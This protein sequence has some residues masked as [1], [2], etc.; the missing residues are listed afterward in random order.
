[1][2]R[3]SN[4]GRESGPATGPAAVVDE[5]AE[6]TP[7]DLRG[8]LLRTPLGI[9][10]RRPRLS[11]RLACG[12]RGA[13]Q[14]SYRV[15][16]AASPADLADPHRVLWDSGQVGSPDEVLVTYDGP[17]LQSA[18]RYHWQVDV[19][20]EGDRPGGSARSWFETGLLH[21]DDWVAAW[22]GRDQNGRP[23]MDPPTDDDLPDELRSLSA[24]M[25]L[26]RPFDLP[27]RP[28]RARVYVTAR[29]L[30]E[31][32]VNG[33]RVGDAELAP[34][35]TEYHHRIPYQ[36]YD[37][38]D[39]LVEGANVLAGVV[40][41]G[42][43]SGYVG[44]DGRRAGRHY[45]DNP[46][47]LAQLVLQFP[48]GSERVVGT[49]SD[50]LERPGPLRHAD[51][52][53]GEYYD[54]REELS[55]WDQ[56]GYD[57]SGWAPAAV[58][59]TVTGPL[60][61]AADEPVR[62]VAELPAVDVFRRPDG[63]YIV[64]LGQNMA[65]RVRLTVR[66]APAGA[67]IQL[68]H[69]EMLTGD[70]EPYTANLRSADA[71]DVYVAAGRPVEVFEPR[72]TYHGFRYV[73]VT[74]YPG[75]LAADDIRGRV[76]SSDTPEA[77]EFACSDAT[78]NQLQSNIRWSQRGNFVAVPTDCP[79]RDER[80]GWLADAQVFLPTAAR[81]NDVAAFMARWLRDVR[82]GQD[83]DGAFRDVAPLL[84]ISREGAPAWGDAG[85]I[86][87]WQLY[88]TYGDKRVLEENFAAMAAWV[89]HVHRHNP[90]LLWRRR[91]G[92]HY[93]DWLQVGVRTPPDVLATAY[94]ARSAALVA[95]AAEA[96]N[97]PDAAKRY[98]ALHAAIRDA[99]VDAFVTPDGRV[100][101]ET[102]T[103]YLLALAFDLL[104]ESLVEPAVRHLVADIEA[105]GRHLSTGF[106]G[107]S[108]L[109]PVLTEHGHA[110]LA[111]KLLHQDTYPSWGYPLRH[112][113][114]TIWE[115]WDGWTEQRGFQSARMNSFNHYS[116]G[117]V[118]D[119][120]YGRVAGI[121]QAPDSVGYRRLLLRPTAG[122][123]L[124]WA[125]AR[126]TAPRGEVACGWR[127][128]GG[129]IEVEVTVPPS[130]TAE[131]HLPTSDPDSLR[132]AGSADGFRVIRTGDG[133]VAVDL[134]SGRYHFAAAA[135]HL[136][137]PNGRQHPERTQA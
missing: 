40:A 37:V 113:A 26:R 51:L 111:Y 70:G 60:C 121:D 50:W 96:I 83:A 3:F 93:G 74:G 68:R 47:F 108:L 101:G 109:C 23:P 103:C 11:W 24:P 75:E 39:L 33:T 104:P 16:V 48:D 102:Q 122:G 87:P 76:L 110:E 98:S 137:Q 9:D 115:R 127:L 84:C 133:H 95:A 100:H 107:V 2:N 61:G 66:S 81:N 34:G 134:T 106:I 13:G 27:G 86:I 17:R 32:Y 72:F 114:T 97:R 89:E 59:D 125:R 124:E 5:P 58:I 42:W 135:P 119:W 18:T 112:G 15:R 20:D 90:D 31:V 92:N 6:L 63:R 44:F 136:P 105:R 129:Q 21:R 19:W 123:R 131:L 36:T 73:E 25:F 94:F 91:T 117:S 118:G 52:L 71:T 77:G 80:L 79:Q 69:A 22:I 67:R 8:E 12:R 57:D 43:W 35:W 120:L 53:K 29:G 49:D 128:T 7:Y 28:V 132:E 4:A 85:V 55:G 78:V 10:E 65:G 64:D 14:R 30:Y 62:V 130:T 56:P 88:R 116:L 54:A 1:M 46:Q 99:F 126:Y 41:D 45:G 38:T 82:D